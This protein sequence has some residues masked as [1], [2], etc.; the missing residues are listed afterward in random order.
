[1]KKSRLFVLLGVSAIVLFLSS[2]ATASFVQDGTGI[3]YFVSVNSYGNYDLKGKTY[4]I[5]SG[6]ENISSNDLEFKEY[7]GYLEENLK[8]QGAQKTTD[9]ENAD[10][11]ILMNYCITDQSYQ[12]TIPIPEYGRTSI[13]STTTKGN[14]TT[15]Q[16]NYGTTGYHYVNR[17]VSKFLRVVN[18]YGYDNKT[19]DSEPIMLWKTNLKSEGFRSDLRTVIPYIFYAGIGKLGVST[20]GETLVTVPEEGYL[21]N[22]WR[23]RKFS[24]QNY[25]LICKEL[26]I[27]KFLPYNPT[28]NSVANN[29]E[30]WYR[31]SLISIEKKENETLVY[32]GKEGSIMSYYLPTELYLCFNGKEI[33]VSYDDVLGKTM[34]KECGPRVFSLHFPVNTYDVSSI[35]LKEYTN[36][37]H[38]KWRSWGVFDITNH[39]GYFS[40][41]N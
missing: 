29:P 31:F 2:C 9:K 34:K 39:N 24:N 12:E 10:L 17:D 38:T 16:Y 7:A 15:Y 11:C 32:I 25:I 14:V 40:F 23:Q 20:N 41:G 13:A 36:E 30:Q 22:C 28:T 4:Y 1:M 3:N 19:L 8:T 33:K 35:E 5:E 21:I 27:N 37:S 26:P 6:D 18:I